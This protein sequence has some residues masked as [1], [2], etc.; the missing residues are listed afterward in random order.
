VQVKMFVR[1]DV[2]E[3]KTGRCKGFELRLDL[4]CNLTTYRCAQPYRRAER[5]H[6]GAKHSVSR[7]EIRDLAGR[8]QRSAVDEHQMQ[9]HAE[10]G[11]SFCAHHRVARGGAAHHQ[12]RGAQYTRAVPRLDGFVDFKRGAEIIGRDDQMAVTT[13]V[14]P[15]TIAFGSETIAVAQRAISRRSRRK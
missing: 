8:K 13:A 11:Q 7:D 15:Q 5:G 12:A 4:R 10:P 2:V 9:A 1:V 6:V 3:S 14:R